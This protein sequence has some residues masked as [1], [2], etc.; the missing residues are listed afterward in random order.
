VGPPRLIPTAAQ[1]DY[2]D[3]ERS[4]RLKFLTT[5]LRFRAGDHADIYKHWLAGEL[6][7]QYVNRSRH[8][9]IKAFTD[10]RN[11]VKTQ[12]C[13]LRLSIYVRGSDRV[14]AGSRRWKLVFT[15]FYSSQCYPF[16]E[17]GPFFGHFRRA[18]PIADLVDIGNQLILFTFCRTALIPSILFVSLLSLNLDLV[19]LRNLGS[20][21]WFL[22]LLLLLLLGCPALW[23][24]FSESKRYP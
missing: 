6:I 15:R 19:T 9:R 14:Q 2:F 4:K 16:R 18:T 8:V 22:V 24:K 20:G 7:L 23:S 10:Q 5:T 13:G 11:A 1:S 21:L 17:N 12:I 3:A